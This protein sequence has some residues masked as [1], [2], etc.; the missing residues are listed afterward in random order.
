MKIAV[1]VNEFPAIS[2]TFILN[3][4]VGLLRRGHDVRIYARASGERADHVR[5]ADIARYRLLDRIQYRTPARSPLARMSSA[6]PRIIRWGW[7]DLG[8]VADSLNVLCYRRPALS[9]RL[10]NELL[11]AADIQP[12][13][14][15]IIHCHYGPNGQ[16]AIAWR[17]FG[18]VSGPIIT[19]FHGYDVNKLPRI[20]GPKLYRELFRRG[21]MFTVGSEFL[22][23]RI[24]ALGAPPDRI[25][26]LPMGID[27][28]RFQFSERTQSI[29]GE[30][31]LLTVARLVEV[32]GI[33]FALLAVA[34][35]KDRYPGIRYQIIGDG[36][37][38]NE[39]EALT[40]RLNIAD[41]VEF[42]GA[43]PQE[44][45]TRRLSFAHVFVLPS[46]V[47]ASGEEEGQS[48]VLAEAQASGLPVIA[49]A[50]GGVA[51]S[52]LDGESGF[53]V[54]PRNPEALAS[55]MLWLADH[56]EAWGRMGRAGRAHVDASFN[57]ERLNDRL[58]DIY[59]AAARCR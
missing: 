24:L 52:V 39:L 36:P 44:E 15:D 47:T 11:P 12:A 1:F 17:N 6:G 41:K 33:E 18:A 9:L 54:P 48:V 2:E 14:Y 45:V 20:Y 58:V 34:S 22:K 37:L 13:P 7:R 56:P 51:E 16:R 25:A 27:P 55:A 53:L 10:L 40:G 57:L 5:H 28:S 21:D 35:L 49:T 8:A 42:L 46:V 3:Q 59:R 50:I 23:G 31:R 4:I 38:R 26:K 43:L 30:F 19:S 32:K 29:D